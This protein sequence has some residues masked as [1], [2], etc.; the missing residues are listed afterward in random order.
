[1]LPSLQWLQPT[2][3]AEA[4]QALG[5]FGE[6]AKV[7]AGG[8]E[9]LLLLRQKL[10]EAEVLIDIKKIGELHHLAPTKRLCASAPA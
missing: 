3:V 9:L 2:T 6:R 1:M 10:L 4:S 8:A 7:Y 5:D